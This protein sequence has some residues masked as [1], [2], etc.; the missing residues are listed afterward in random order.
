M[1]AQ[2]SLVWFAIAVAGGVSGSLAA[3]RT[4]PPTVTALPVLDEPGAQRT[5]PAGT[6]VDLSL[7]TRLNAAT[8]KVDERFDATTINALVRGTVV[9]LE[10]ATAR[11]FVSSVRPAGQ[12]RSTLTLSFHELRAGERTARLRAAILQVYGGRPERERGAGLA[13]PAPAES[14]AKDRIP[15]AG[16]LVDATGTITATDGRSVD[17]P[18]G[19]ILRMRLLEPL[20]VRVGGS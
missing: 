3:Q 5:L 10:G 6:D 2:R 15:L 17:L 12:G 11:G 13:V 14:T 1:R 8:V 19:T 4:S 16:V 18:A 9:M 7:Q 20:D